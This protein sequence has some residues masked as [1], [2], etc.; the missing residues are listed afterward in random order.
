MY[1]VQRE[2]CIYF[3]KIFLLETYIFKSS[4]YSEY[5]YC[6]VL[7]LKAHSVAVFTCH[8]ARYLVSA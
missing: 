5:P 8:S 1:V 6:S 7:N 2:S 4:F 3:V